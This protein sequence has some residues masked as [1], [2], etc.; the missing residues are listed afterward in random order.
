MLKSLNRGETWEK[1]EL[2]PPEKKVSIHAVVINP[3]NTKE[4]LKKYDSIVK[5]VFQ[6]N[7]GPASARN[8][9]LR[10]A[11]GNYIAFLDDDDYFLPTKIEK[12]INAMKKYKIDISCT[13]AYNGYG[14]YDKNKEYKK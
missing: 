4:I 2:I 10:M 14:I 11:Q 6:E 7:N 1:I 9:G 12:Q 13:E 3:D 8:R 5:Y